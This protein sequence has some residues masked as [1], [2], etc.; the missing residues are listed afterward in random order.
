MYLFSVACFLVLYIA[1]EPE[2]SLALLCAPVS[3]LAITSHFGIP[4]AY[5]PVV[6]PDHP[7]RG[8]S[9]ENPQFAATFVP[10]GFDDYYMPEVI[11]PAP[12]R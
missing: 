6:H 8:E 2:A 5:H 12:Q 1:R 9:L 10:G 4:C 11:A 3:H 7:A